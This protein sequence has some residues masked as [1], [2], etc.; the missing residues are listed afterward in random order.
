MH[1]GNTNT[2]RNVYWTSPG[3]SS[4]ASDAS[5]EESSNNS[6]DTSNEDPDEEPYDPD[7]DLEEQD[8]SLEE[9]E[10]EV[11]PVRQKVKSV[12]TLIIFFLIRIYLIAM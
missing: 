6:N 8:E 4:E 5:L 1:T 9:D 3:G 2:L 12:N 10:G 11:A 7:Q